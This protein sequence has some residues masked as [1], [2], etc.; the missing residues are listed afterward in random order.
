MRVI[1]VAIGKTSARDL[2]NVGA[3][4]VATNLAE[5]HAILNGLTQGIRNE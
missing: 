5:C 4:H 2:R 1:G 3:H